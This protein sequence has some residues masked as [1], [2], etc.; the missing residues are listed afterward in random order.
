MIS[1]NKVYRPEREI[2]YERVNSNGYI[3]IKVNNGVPH[4]KRWKLKHVLIYER[5]HGAVPDGKRIGFKDGNKANLADENL[6]VT[7]REEVMQRNAFHNYP[8]EVKNLIV[9]RGILNREI[10]KIEEEK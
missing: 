4:H 1:S 10:N 5:L 9:A 8:P 6:T 2:G 7:T 3:E